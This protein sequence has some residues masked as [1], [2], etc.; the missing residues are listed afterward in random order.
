MRVLQVCNKLPFP[1]LDGGSLVMHQATLGLQ[2]LGCE[3][4]V[5]AVSTPKQTIHLDSVDPAYLANTQ[6]RYVH[7]DTRIKAKDAFFNLF[8]SLP[9]H[10]SR[11]QTDECAER[12]V[13][14]VKNGN[15]DVVQFESL[16]MLVYLPLIRKNS[17]ATI[18][19]RSQNVE[20]TIWE[21]V[22]ANSSFLP[23]RL[24]LGLQSKRLARFEAWACSNADGVIAIT[25][26]DEKGLRLMAAETPICTIPIGLDLNKY[27]DTS[28]FDDQE[29]SIFHL[30]SM[31]W[32]PNEE[33][34]RWFLEEVWPLIKSQKT[35]TKLYLAGKHMQAWIKAL[36]DPNLIV[37]DR[38]DDPIGYMTDK[39]IMVV[40]LKSGSG[41]RVK[42]LEGMAMGKVVVSTSVG[43][44]GIACE[45]GHDLIIADTPEQMAQSIVEAL[46]QG[47]AMKKMGLAARAC[48]AQHYDNQVLARRFVEF[49]EQLEGAK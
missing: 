5:F 39:Q 38:I 3:V 32:Y 41:I 16:Y 31:D 17:T 36:A 2:S 22:A 11:Y 42:I 24:W 4:T 7:I 49:Y 18:V 47:A 10:V 19:Y 30:G 6:L 20:Y 46:S 27:P 12:L 44:D 48:I 35:D 33:A 23:K 1:A 43:A 21:K 25:A 45:P 14:V 9:Y 34:V 37:E 26:V 40:P 8:S 28:G 15:Y 13:E 29:S